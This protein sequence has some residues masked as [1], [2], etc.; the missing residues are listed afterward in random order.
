MICIYHIFSRSPIE[1]PLFHIYYVAAMN[2]LEQ[3]SSY[4][5]FLLLLDSQVEGFL[6][7]RVNAFLVLIDI[8]FLNIFNTSDFILVTLSDHCQPH[9]YE[10]ISLILFCIHFWVVVYH[11]HMIEPLKIISELILYR[12]FPIELLF[13]SD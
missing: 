8:A 13:S 1:E 2:T 10:E 11:F 9:G 4:C 12:F 6:C 5:C 3:I 7:Q